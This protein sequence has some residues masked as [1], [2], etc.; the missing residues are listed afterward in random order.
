MGVSEYLVW[1][2]RY[3]SDFEIV[4]RN[5]D[6]SSSSLAYLPSPIPLF[7]IADD[8]ARVFTPEIYEVPF[9]GF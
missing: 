3:F 4:S 9:S 5:S 2:F 7:R 8:F 1:I 6:F